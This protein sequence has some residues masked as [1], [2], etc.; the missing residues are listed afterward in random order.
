MPPPARVHVQSTMWV[1][2]DGVILHSQPYAS[3]L[4]RQYREMLCHHCYSA[5]PSPGLGCAEC[6]LVSY[7]SRRCLQAAAPTHSLECALVS[8][9]GEPEDPTAWLLLRVWLRWTAERRHDWGP[10]QEGEEGELVPGSK[11]T[12]KFSDFLSHEQDIRK[13]SKKMNHI[14]QHYEELEQILLEDM[15]AFQEFVRFYGMVVINDFELQQFEGEFEDESLGLGVYLTPSIINHSCSPNAFPEFRGNKMV[16]RSLVDQPKV[17]M[18]NVFI[19]Y[20]DTEEQDGESRREFLL[21]H[22]F[23]TCVCSKCVCCSTCC[24]ITCVC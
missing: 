15:P 21:S 1:K 13:S 4:Y 3:V 5:A 22:Y 11:D 24:C 12:R 7:C 23:F 6:C 19:G 9:G 14:T 20:T 8:C 2:K 17:D 18:D 10:F 16:L